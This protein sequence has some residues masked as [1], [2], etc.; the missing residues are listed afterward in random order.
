VFDF[1]D[2]GLFTRLTSWYDSHDVRS[3]LREARK[4]AEGVRS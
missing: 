2:E 3:R 4:A 1:N